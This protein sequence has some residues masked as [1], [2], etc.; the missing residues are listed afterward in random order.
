MKPRPTAVDDLFFADQYQ[1]VQWRCA[2]M[3]SGCIAV[4]GGVP[5]LQGLDYE[6]RNQ[7]MNKGINHIRLTNNPLEKRFA[8][9]WAKMNKD[10]GV[11]KFMLDRTHQ[12][13]GS[14][15]V[16]EVENEVAATVIQWL[17]SHVGECFIRDVMEAHRAEF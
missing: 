13:R 4:C 9:A 5:N 14:H 12:N 8:E 7:T 1:V 15:S 2:P 3:K 6:Q 16:A 17:G 10:N 11:L